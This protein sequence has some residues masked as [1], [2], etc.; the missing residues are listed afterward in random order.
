MGTGSV[1]SQPTTFRIPLRKAPE[2][3]A[4]VHLIALSAPL[5]QPLLLSCTCHC[6]RCRKRWLE[7][8]AQYQRGSA[9]IFASLSDRNAR[10]LGKSWGSSKVLGKSG[11]ARKS[12]SRRYPRCWIPHYRKRSQ[13]CH[14][15][16]R[17]K[18]NVHP[19]LA[20]SWCTLY[21]DWSGMKQWLSTY[22]SI[23]CTIL[24]SRIFFFVGR[25]EAT[26]LSMMRAEFKPFTA[27]FLHLLASSTGH[28]L[29]T[30]RA[31]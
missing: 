19:A 17:R 22:S 18:G 27:G 2:P 21:S 14:R 25:A 23:C 16:R 13:L 24:K 29:P 30:Q 31:H 26:I 4:V 11:P 28:A 7:L 3:S 9:Q 12:W 20:D 8:S 10:V 1:E 15:C 6:R 5:W